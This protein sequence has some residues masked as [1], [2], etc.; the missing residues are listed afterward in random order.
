[1]KHV[2]LL[3][4]FKTIPFL[5]Y[6]FISYA[7]ILFV[8]DGNTGRSYMANQIAHYFLYYPSSSRGL[9]VKSTMVEPNAKEALKEWNIDA[10]YTPQQIS[11]DDIIAADKV[12]TMTAKQLKTLKNQYPKYQKK[13][14]MISV[15]AG[16][17]SIDVVDPYGHDLSFYK[18][19]RDQIYKYEQLISANNWKC[20]E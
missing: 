1:M 9:D 20:K 6:S 10:P 7:Q 11:E 18:N 5:L 16:F 17:S 15:C 12:L 14:E 2:G 8:C 19:V 3:N 13:I 4:I